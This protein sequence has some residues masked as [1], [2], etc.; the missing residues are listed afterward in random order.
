MTFVSETKR[1]RRKT[2]FR[3]FPTPPSNC[4]DP[5]CL[6]TVIAIAKLHGHVLCTKVFGHSPAGLGG[7]FVRRR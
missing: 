7:V 1:G 4:T 2:T 6:F 3:G 5:R